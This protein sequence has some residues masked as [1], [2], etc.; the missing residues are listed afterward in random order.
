KL[1]LSSIINNPNW[2]IIYLDDFMIVLIKKGENLNLKLKEVNLDLLNP[3]QY[4][5][6]EYIPY[7]RMSFF[8]LNTNHIDAAK[9]F[10]QKALKISPEILYSKNTIWW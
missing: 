2:Q 5:F 3:S 4:Q 1:F 9:L 6:N 7:L 10:T 8:L